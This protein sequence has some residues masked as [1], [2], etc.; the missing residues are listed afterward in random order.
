[1]IIKMEKDGATL[2]QGENVLLIHEGDNYL[3]VTVG[4]DQAGC[5]SVFRGTRSERFNK[6]FQTFKSEFAQE[7]LGVYLS[8]RR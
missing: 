1:M 2:R 8:Q 4:K 5:G 6:A 7:A 3:N